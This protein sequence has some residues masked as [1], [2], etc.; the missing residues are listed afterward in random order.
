[1]LCVYF[2]V[3]LSVYVCAVRYTSEVSAHATLI[4]LD[5]AVWISMGI[6]RKHHFVGFV[7]VC[8]LA[9]VL[10]IYIISLFD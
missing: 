4:G 3:H 8:V 9:S 2:R 6:N 7:V 5:S 1:M 10:H